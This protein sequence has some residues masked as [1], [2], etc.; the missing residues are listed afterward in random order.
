MKLGITIGAGAGFVGGI[1]AAL[2]LSILG[3]RGHEGEITRAIILVSQ[4]VGS[5]RLVVGGLVQIAVA[6]AIGGLF[7]VLYEAAGL[8][9]ESVAAW[10]TIYGIAW[11]IV[12]WF[13]V[14]PR[15]LRFAPWEAV[16]DPALFQ[17]AVAGLLAC[18]G[19]GTVIAGAFTLFGRAEASASEARLRA[20][21]VVASS[22]RALTEGR[23]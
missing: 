21:R 8:R 10:A 14:M 20:A 16:E 11:W 17:L 7:G 6:T 19:F 1:V 12:G 2:M 23:R 4:T 18:L 13:A 9:R 5:D 3:I 22:N 15:P